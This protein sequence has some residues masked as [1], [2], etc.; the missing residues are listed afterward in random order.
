VSARGHSHASALT[1]P[2]RHLAMGQEV[3]LE[4]GLKIPV[5][6]PDPDSNDLL[7]C[8]MVIKRSNEPPWM[9]DQTV[10]R[11]VPLVQQFL[12]NIIRIS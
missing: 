2:S 7:Y 3:F 4:P 12:Q 10:A 8:I 5:G 9:G 11:P 1:V 6:V